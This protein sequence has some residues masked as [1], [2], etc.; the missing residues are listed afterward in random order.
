MPRRSV[1][2]QLPRE[3]QDQ[4]HA[5]IRQGRTIEEITA[6]LA[7]LDAEVSRSAVGR[8]VQRARA[9][10]ERYKAAQE[11]AAQLIPAF[12]EQAQGDVGA[13]AAEA[14]KTLVHQA[15][16]EVSDEDCNDGKMPGK[17]MLLG[18]ALE[19]AVKTTKIST[20]LRARIRKEALE[21]AAK[22]VQGAGKRAGLSADAIKLMEQELRLL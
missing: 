7:A 15:L 5:L 14:I 6:H 19:S 8:Y 20:E 12:G 9:Q 11:L 10:M 13:L 1:I 21:E 16:T 3:V 17:M 18:R 2:T 4:V 22:A